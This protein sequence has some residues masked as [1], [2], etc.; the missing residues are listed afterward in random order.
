MTIQEQLIKLNNTFESLHRDFSA[1]E[2]QR[3]NLDSKYAGIISS[4]KAKWQ[5][6]YDK[7]NQLKEEILKYFRI[8]ELLLKGRIWLS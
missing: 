7:Q 2:A 4:I 6:E 3:K 1:F 5:V 8:A